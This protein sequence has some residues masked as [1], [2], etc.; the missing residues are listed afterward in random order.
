[1]SVITNLKEALVRLM[2]EEV[3]LDYP[4]SLVK[5]KSCAPYVMKMLVSQVESMIELCTFIALLNCHY[6]YAYFGSL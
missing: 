6:A 3:M 2:N 5:D 1:M 4:R